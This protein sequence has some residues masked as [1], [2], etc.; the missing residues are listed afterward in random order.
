MEMVIGPSKTERG[1]RSMAELEIFAKW[2]D[3]LKWLLTVTDSFPRKARF[4]FTTRIDNTA[5]DLLED[6]I[7]CRYLPS[8]RKNRLISMNIRLE[9]MRILLRICTELRYLS[10]RQLE[11]GVVHINEV[12]KMVH[13]WLESDVK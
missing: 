4:T 6:I 1:M 12:G 3:F 8:V 10:P 7:E 9:K 13:G 2:T 11:Y 5:L